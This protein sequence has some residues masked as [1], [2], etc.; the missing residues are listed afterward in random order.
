MRPRRPD[1]ANLTQLLQ[2]HESIN[3]AHICHVDLLGGQEDKG[4]T[5]RNQSDLEPNY[6]VNPVRGGAGPDRGRD[7]WHAYGEYDGLATW[8]AAVALGHLDTAAQRAESA[9]YPA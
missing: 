6:L 8:K 1:L 2:S 5:A 9:V 3:E 7:W 4:K